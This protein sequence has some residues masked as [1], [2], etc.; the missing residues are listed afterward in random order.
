MANDK[1]FIGATLTN[2]F[3]FFYFLTS[4]YDINTL[5][6]LIITCG[7]IFTVI[8]FCLLSDYIFYIFM[9]GSNLND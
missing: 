6:Y 1:F 8:L 7:F 4:D 5:S 2:C 9:D 3:W